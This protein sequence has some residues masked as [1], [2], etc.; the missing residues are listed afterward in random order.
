LATSLDAAKDKAGA[1]RELRLALSTAQ[2]HPVLFGPQVEVS[3]AVLAIFLAQQGKQ[4]EAKDIAGP[5]CSSLAGKPAA[6]KL[7]KLLTD[8]HLCD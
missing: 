8:Q 6:E 4:D 2:A 3:R 5:A 7:L 1:E